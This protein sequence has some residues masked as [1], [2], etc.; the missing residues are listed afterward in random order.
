MTRIYTTIVGCINY[1][2]GDILSSLISELSAAGRG[3][4]RFLK[5]NVIQYAFAIEFN[6]NWQTG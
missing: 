1:F 4:V 6:S 3:E 5:R 2:A